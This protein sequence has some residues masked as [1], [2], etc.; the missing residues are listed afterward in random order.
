[1]PRYLI[2]VPHDPSL[3]GC[4]RALEALAEQGSHFIARTDW[5]CEVGEHKGWLIVEAEDDTDAQRM[6][7]P[8]IRKTASVV[9]LNRFTPERWQAEHQSPLQSTLESTHGGADAVGGGAHEEATPA[10]ELG[11]SYTA[12][13]RRW[14]A[15]SPYRQIAERRLRS[16]PEGSPHL[17]KGASMNGRDKA[18]LAGGDTARA[19]VRTQGGQTQRRCGEGRTER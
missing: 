4:R 9:R 14:P 19:Q 7:P 12:W 8:V 6:V 10:D 1:M 17:S 11:V 5:G 15:R 3:L 16:R 18:K 13:G 2:Q